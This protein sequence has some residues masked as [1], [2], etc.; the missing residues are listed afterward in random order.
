MTLAMGVHGETHADYRCHDIADS[1]LVNS[2]FDSCLAK[3]ILRN[4]ME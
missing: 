1:R 2:R 3:A 4:E